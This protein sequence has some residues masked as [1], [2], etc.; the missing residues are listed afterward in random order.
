MTAID[1]HRTPGQGAVVEA[2]DALD[3]L[4]RAET[5]RV[6]DARTEAASALWMSDSADVGVDVVVDGVVDVDADVDADAD[7]TAA[8]EVLEPVACDCGA[9]GVE[10]AAN[11]AKDAVSTAS[12]ARPGRCVLTCRLRRPPQQHCG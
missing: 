8:T 10:Q 3:G 1:T 12:R 5:V 11:T 2:G 4:F 6:G 7:V 9:A